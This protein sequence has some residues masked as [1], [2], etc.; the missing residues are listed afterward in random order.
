VVSYKA[1]NVQADIISKL[2]TANPE[3]AKKRK[4][5]TGAVSIRNNCLA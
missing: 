5:I 3:K 2:T 4:I 1:A